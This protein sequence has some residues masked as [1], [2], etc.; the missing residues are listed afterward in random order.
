[1]R[2]ES[3]TGNTSCGVVVV[4]VVNVVE[5][6]FVEVLLVA[7]VEKPVVPTLPV[8]LMEALLLFPRSVVVVNDDVLDVVVLTDV[9]VLLDVVDVTVVRVVVVVVVVNMY[10]FAP[11]RSVQTR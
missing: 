8:L 9:E 2:P 6:E 1:M 4:K 5:D 7:R 11:S 10:V 3:P